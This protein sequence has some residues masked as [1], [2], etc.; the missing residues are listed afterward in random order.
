MTVPFG[1]EFR[2]ACFTSLDPEVI[3]VNNGSF[4]LSPTPVLEQLHKSTLELYSF[5]DRLYRL[6]LK[7]TYIKALKLL[8]PVVKTDYTNLAIV[9][10]ATSGLNSFLRSPEI[11]KHG[12]TIIISSVIYG[13]IKNLV[14]FLRTSQS[15]KVRVVNLDIPKMAPQDIVDVFEA[16]IKTAKDAGETVKA[17]VFDLVSSMPAIRLPFEDLVALCRNHDVL[18]VIDGAHGIG[19]LELDLD[20]LAPDFL[21]LNLHKWYYVPV[22]SAVMYVSPKWH[23]KIMSLPISWSYSVDAFD[24]S[25]DPLPLIDKFYYTGTKTVALLLCIKT[26]I[27]FREKECGGEHKIIDYCN[28]LAHTVG[29]VISKR[30]GTDILDTSNQD[31]TTAMVNVRLPPSALDDLPLS[32]AM[33]QQLGDIEMENFNTFVPI[34]KWNGHW[35]ARFSC[36]VYNDLFD[37]EYAADK[38][39]E[40]ISIWRIRNKLNL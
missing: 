37:F 35:Y 1:K 25:S 38:L 3:P 23:T 9:D 4:G 8:A 30:W 29:D 27:D 17:C 12:D 11:I 10:N 14:D 32:R 22:G 28:Q 5:P 20:K 2:K 13:A 31:Y 15:V 18:S 33:D 26:A 24:S 16:E 34:T 36:Q 19:M 40:A 21:V 39:L 7:S 6:H